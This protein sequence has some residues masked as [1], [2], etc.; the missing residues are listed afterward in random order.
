MHLAT[1]LTAMH[2]P[3]FQHPASHVTA[4]RQTQD[5]QIS[6]I[7]FKSIAYNV[8]MVHNTPGSIPLLTLAPSPNPF[9]FLSPENNSV[10]TS[11]DTLS[12][13]MHV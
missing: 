1:P 10:S 9:G 3:P 7:D 5:T 2:S 11:S 8:V 6:W 13:F 12:L 4:E